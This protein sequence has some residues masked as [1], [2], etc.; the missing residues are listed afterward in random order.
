MLKRFLAPALILG[1]ASSGALLSGCGE[2]T[3]PKKEEPA[4]APASP[5]PTDEKGKMSTETPPPS[6]EPA[7]PAEPAKAP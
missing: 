2:T 1:I 5:T 6:G 7:K 3:E 4:A